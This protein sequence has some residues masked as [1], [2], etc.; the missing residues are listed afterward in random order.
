MFPNFRSLADKRHKRQQLL[1]QIQRDQEF[2]HI[3]NNAYQTADWASDQAKLLALQQEEL[4][5]ATNSIISSINNIPQPAPIKLEQEAEAP[6]QAT[7]V[8]SSQQQA[9]KSIKD[10][11]VHNPSLISKKINPVKSSGSI[12]SDVYIGENGDLYNINT[13]RL[14]RKPDVNFDFIATLNYLNNLALNN[15][16]SNDEELNTGN[17]VATDESPALFNKAT[18]IN[19]IKT[20][21]F[22]FKVIPMSKHYQNKGTKTLKAIHGYYIDQNGSIRDDNTN[23]V[24]DAI[25]G[26]VSWTKSLEA[27]LRK[28]SS[29]G[30][31]YNSKY[32][33]KTSKV[34]DRGLD[35]APIYYNE[36][37]MTANDLID[38]ENDQYST[39]N[40]ETMHVQKV[41]EL[42]RLN[43][44]LPKYYISP[45]PIDTDIFKED[46][47]Y[48]GANA[49][50]F[51]TKRERKLD[52]TNAY[53]RKIYNNVDWK[54]TFE[55]ILK[56]YEQGMFDNHNL[57]ET[58]DKIIYARDRGVDD[59]IDQ[60]ANRAN[61]RS[62]DVNVYGMSGLGLGVRGRRA[63]LNNE[64]YKLSGELLLGNRHKAIRRELQLLNNYEKR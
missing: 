58:N 16:T 14:S 48:L 40:S 52:L 12:D 47:Y 6:A 61:M 19:L 33:I 7:S 28:L 27:L 21:D 46:T 26:Q 43:K 4:V 44:W 62:D 54:E 38:N 5:Q 20:N 45:I 53:S 63:I 60:F 3:K 39:F 9:K 42:Y 64:R 22:P 32:P 25:V 31:N 35:G 37:A 36:A 56:D 15:L 8:V 30:I 51:N 41:K 49:E 17:S 13:D 50:L 57:V 23:Q 34:I 1:A 10:I 59:S 55:L 2:E 11:Y 24:N 29:E 18:L